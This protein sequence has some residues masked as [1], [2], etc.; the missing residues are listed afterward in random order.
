MTLSWN[1]RRSTKYANDHST[2]DLQQT[3]KATLPGRYLDNTDRS[4]RV[5]EPHA[6]AGLAC[7]GDGIF[8][9]PR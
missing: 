3:G 4:D 9:P 7:E 2:R 8:R 6:L 5:F 1:K